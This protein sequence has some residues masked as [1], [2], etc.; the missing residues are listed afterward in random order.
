MRKKKSFFPSFSSISLSIFFGLRF[1]TIYVVTQKVNNKSKETNNCIEVI[2]FSFV[3]SIYHSGFVLFVS[4][5]P[6]RWTCSISIFRWEHRISEVK[7]L[8]KVIRL[9]N[10]EAEILMFSWKREQEQIKTNFLK[11]SSM[12]ERWHLVCCHF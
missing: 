4:K 10:G 1:R 6:Y 11:S 2:F 7:Q 5:H 12:A 8:G 9:I 3:L